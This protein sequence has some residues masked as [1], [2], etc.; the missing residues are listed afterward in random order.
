[1]ISRNGTA[2]RDC[3]TTGV[4]IAS[5]AIDSILE[6]ENGEGD[7]RRTSR[8]QQRGRTHAFQNRLID[9][10][11]GAKPVVW[12]RKPISTTIFGEIVHNSAV[13]D[14]KSTRNRFVGAK[15]ASIV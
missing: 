8:T 7:G 13:A 4:R 1:M 12:K 5:F 9:V 11:I 3:I 14:A 6:S 2:A 15:Y 10:V